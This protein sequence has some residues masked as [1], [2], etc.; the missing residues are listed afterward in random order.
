MQRTGIGKEGKIG[1]VSAL[2]SASL[3]LT[4]LMLRDLS[5]TSHPRQ[6]R[7]SGLLRLLLKKP[8]LD[9]LFHIYLVKPCSRA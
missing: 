2:L 7:S 4:K 3:S 5:A 9:R 8:S 6:K 1:W